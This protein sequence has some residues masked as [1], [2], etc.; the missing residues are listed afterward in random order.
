MG[1]PLR[2]VPMQLKNRPLS[3]AMHLIFKDLNT[4]SIT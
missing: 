4:I 2:Y 1:L 3:S